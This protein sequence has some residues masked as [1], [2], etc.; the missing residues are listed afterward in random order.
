VL[1]KLVKFDTF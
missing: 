1:Q